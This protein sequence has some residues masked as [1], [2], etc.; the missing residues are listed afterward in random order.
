MDSE[1]HIVDCLA[2]TMHE[3]GAAEQGRK[4]LAQVIGLGLEQAFAMLLPEDDRRRHLH[5]CDVYREIFLNRGPSPSA[6]FAGAR[7]AV[8]TLTEQGYL[9]A[10]ATGKS[11]RG[12]DKVL[13]ESG[14]EPYFPI[15]RCADET[16]SKPNPLMLEEILVD[17]D[18]EPHQAVM[19]GDTE[20]DLQMATNI[21][22]D[23]IGVSF[24]V[25]DISRLMRHNPLA[26]LNQLTELPDFLTQYQRAD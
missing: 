4:E 16:L 12:L 5:A 21:R 15:T 22:M 17:L 11:R 10:V 23:S 2:E 6:L 13:D 26:I 7:E 20:F 9:L 25:H 3:L 14:L 24:G 8:H 1:A 18:A 19:I